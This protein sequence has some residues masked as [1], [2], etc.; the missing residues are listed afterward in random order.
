MVRRKR[1]AK[2]IGERV[3]LQVT[4]C[5]MVALVDVLY[6]TCVVCARVRAAPC[7]LTTN[8]DSIPTPPLRPFSISAKE[9]RESDVEEWQGALV[10]VYVRVGKVPDPPASR[11]PAGSGPPPMR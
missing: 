10:R 4:Q 2:Q 9:G 3:Q 11:G 6:R 7:A 1:T 8:I 5:G